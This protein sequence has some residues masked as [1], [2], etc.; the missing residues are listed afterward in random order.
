MFLEEGEGWA[1]VLM[2]DAS[3]K[4]WNISL[5]DAPFFVTG[6][7]GWGGLQRLWDNFIYCSN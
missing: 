2:L 6:G 7:R 5:H 4:Q 3:A 1:G